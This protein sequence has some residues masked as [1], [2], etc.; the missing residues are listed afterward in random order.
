MGH[1]VCILIALVWVHSDDTVAEEPD[2]RADEL[3]SSQ[4]GPRVPI[5]IVKCQT[6]LPT[7]GLSRKVFLKNF[8]FNLQAHNKSL[9]LVLVVKCL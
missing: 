6:G 9:K 7:R 8:Q 5:G 1:K 3:M 2:S 4:E